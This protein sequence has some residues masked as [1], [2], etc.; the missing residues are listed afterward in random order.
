MVGG[1]VVGD[2][3][4]SRGVRWLGG[5]S[6]VSGRRVAEGGGDDQDGERGDGKSAADED[7]TPSVPR[8]LLLGR[9]LSL[10]LSDLFD[11]VPFF[12]HATRSVA[13]DPPSNTISC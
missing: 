5:E 7:Q 10:R 13:A 8:P 9:R 4:T 2:G 11:V 1:P 3:L 12:G 6:Q